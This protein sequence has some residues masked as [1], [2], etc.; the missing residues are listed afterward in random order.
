MDS[1]ILFLCHLSSRGAGAAI[2][3]FLTDL[4][5]RF[6]H[7]HEIGHFRKPIGY[8]GGHCRSNPT[9]QRPRLIEECYEWLRKYNSA[10]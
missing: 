1:T 3:G 7:F 9:R 5:E 6:Q 8:T 10:S 4:P 2:E